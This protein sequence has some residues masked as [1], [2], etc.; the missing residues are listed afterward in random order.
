MKHAFMYLNGNLVG[1]FN[2][3]EWWDGINLEDLE[4]LPEYRGRGYS[5]R[6]LDFAT[7]KLNVEYLA[8]EK[9]NEVALHVYKKYGFT[10]VGEDAKYWYMKLSCESAWN[11]ND[12][13]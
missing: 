2:T 10:I 13:K 5:Y 1:H 4:V 3:F 8:V 9:N 6:L 12:G 11:N 7:K